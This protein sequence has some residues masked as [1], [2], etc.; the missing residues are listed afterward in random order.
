MH[1]HVR[2]TAQAKAQA[3]SCGRAWLTRDCG[4]LSKP[5]VQGRGSIGG[6]AKG[7]QEVSHKG[8]FCFALLGCSDLALKIVGGWGAAAER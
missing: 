5:R 4:W 2:D 3:G 1:G 7:R 6:Q 8:G